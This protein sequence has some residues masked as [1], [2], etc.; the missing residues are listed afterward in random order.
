MRS[1]KFFARM[2]CYAKNIAA[3]HAGTD[4]FVRPVE[5]SETRG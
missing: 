3:K 1:A 4:A 5:R 2:L